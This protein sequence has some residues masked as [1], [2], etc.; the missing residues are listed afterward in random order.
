MELFDAQHEGRRPQ[1]PGECFGES[2][3]FVDELVKVIR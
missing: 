1:R 2:P 3:A